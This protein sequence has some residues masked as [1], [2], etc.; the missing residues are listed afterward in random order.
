M[1]SLRLLYGIPDS[2]LRV[3]YNGV[4]Y[5]FWNPDHVHEQEIIDFKKDNAWNG[6]FVVLYFG[7]A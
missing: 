3:V 2:K 1:N 6:R 4:D 5:D 7:H